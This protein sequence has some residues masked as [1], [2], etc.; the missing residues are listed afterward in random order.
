MNNSKPSKTRKRKPMPTKVRVII[1]H[2]APT[3][4]IARGVAAMVAAGARLRSLGHIL[5]DEPKM[6]DSAKKD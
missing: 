4:K 3:E 1:R 2:T 5:D 6:N